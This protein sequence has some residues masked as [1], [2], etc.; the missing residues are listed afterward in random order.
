MGSLDDFWI[1]HWGHDRLGVGRKERNR[2]K[3]GSFRFSSF[4]SAI[5][6]MGSLHF[7]LNRIG[8]IS[9]EDWMAT[10]WS[11]PEFEGRIEVRPS[12]FRGSFIAPWLWMLLISTAG[13]LAQTSSP[14]TTNQNLP[15]LTSA[16]Q[17]LELSAAEARR[18]YPIRFRA[19]VTYFNEGWNSLFI[20]DSTAGVFITP[21]YESTARPGQLLEV[22]GIT[23]QGEFAPVITQSHWRVVGENQLPVPRRVAFDEISFGWEDSQWIEVQGVVRSAEIE[24]EQLRLEIVLGGG[25]LR[26]WVKEFGNVA[27]GRLV[28]ATVR[29]R[30]VC[31]AMFN[32]K[33]QMLGAQLYVS[34]IGDVTVVKPPPPDPFGAVTRPIETILQYSQR[35]IGQRVKVVGVVTHYLPGHALFLRDATASLRAQTRQTESVAPG[36]RVEVVGFP[37]SGEQT[38]ILENAIYRIVGHD[39]APRPV[40]VNI[41]QIYKGAFHAE[42]VQIEG[43]L[44]EHSDRPQLLATSRSPWSFTNQLAL[45]IQAGNWFFNAELPNTRPGDLGT[46]LRNGSRLQL[47]GICLVELHDHRSPEQ[48]RILLRSP[49]D[50]VALSGPPWWTARRAMILLGTLAS[51]ALAAVG[52]VIALR[53]QVRRQTDQMRQRLEKETAIERRYRDLVDNATDIVYTHD[54][55][56]K[57][58]SFNPAG[59]RITG[60]ATH[61]AVGMNI[62]QLV[63]PDQLPLAREMTSRKMRGD[64]VT[65]YELDLITKR[66]RRVTVE[67]S[68]RPIRENGTTV[69]IQGFARDVTERKRAQ[70]ILQ[71]SEERKKAILES[72][73]DCIITIDPEGHIIEFNPASEKAFGC[74]R[75][76]ALGRPISELVVFGGGQERHSDGA[77]H[78]L[79]TGEVLILGT[80]MEL[81]AVRADNTQFPVEV[82]VTRIESTEPSDFTVFL[83][84]ISER[85][86]SEVRSAAFSDLGQ[87]LSLATSAEEAAWVVVDTAD[88]LLGWDACYMHLF[89]P[90]LQSV[91]PVLNYD[92]VN[93]RRTQVPWRRQDHKLAPVDRRVVA[94]GA[95]LVLR[96][97]AAQPVPG[98]VPFGDKD[99][100]SASLMFVPLRHLM[101]VVGILS[102]QSYQPNAYDRDSLGILQSLADLCAGAMDRVQAATA[103]AESEERFSKAFR[104]SPLPINISTLKEGFYLDVND[105]FLRLLGYS[106][107]EVIGRT[108]LELGIWMNPT[109][110]TEMVQRVLLDKSV[111]D[112]EIKVRTKTGQVRTVLA[113]FETIQLGPEP[114]LIGISYDVT[115][116]LQLEGQLRHAQKM[117]AVGQL[118]AG[119]AH[120]FNNIMTIIQGHTSLVLGSLAPHSDACES[121]QEVSKAADRAANLTRQLLTF[122]RRQIMQPRPL[123]LNDIANQILRML[124]S[125]LREDIALE[126]ALEPGLPSLPADEGMMEQVIMNLVVNARDAMPQGGRLQVSTQSVVIDEEDLTHRPEAQA[127]RFVCLT[128][129]DTGCGMDAGTLGRIFEPFFTTKDVGRGTG[130]GLATVYGIVKQHQGWIEVKSEKEIGS[131]FQ[132]FL[133]VTPRD[134]D[135]LTKSYPGLSLEPALK[136]DHA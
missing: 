35:D 84:D 120:D 41:D 13:V 80:R 54:L 122:S 3:E 4:L 65:I 27:P 59:E 24:F 62:S 10:L 72:T 82:A 52:C 113:S 103:L 21:P 109:D 107:D 58:T 123:N 92:V 101:K 39:D 14:A 129:A 86:R 16:K 2:S 43:K 100:L 108:S 131:T 118:A 60:H 77:F 74:S 106:R 95:Q 133:P 124:A 114:C 67:I 30:G 112:M 104:M 63:A 98:L 32:Q 29:V 68:S 126:C 56:G 69:G 53:K 81:S 47:T 70:R 102:I 99:R 49:R 15:L 36:D 128:V 11:V 34:D 73:L 136:G 22:E 116:R 87:N 8:T 130:L 119:I 46:T 88:K 64:P 25:R 20:Q 50:I 66:G 121:L 55:S 57:I 94:E 115:E 51:V 37:G 71:Q 117:E 38:P 135:A 45:V 33:R 89:T 9:Q 75:D 48:F 78:V 85:R 93:G 28:E 26:L 91:I 1:A 17:V 6:F 83:R 105:S 44:I 96:Q 127:G 110:R 79:P 111:R 76:Q 97:D 125:V 19:A 7:L 61:E 23:G 132:V 18:G 5:R 90:D 40:P 12:R 31:G 134:T 42:L